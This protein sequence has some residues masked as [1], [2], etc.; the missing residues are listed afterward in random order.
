ML[1]RSGAVVPFDEVAYHRGVV[2]RGMDPDHLVAALGGVERIAD[3][4]EHRHAI[5][6]RVVDR[7]GG[8]LQPDRAMGADQH[9]LVLDLGIAMRE[10]DRGFLMRRG[11]E[12][13]RDILAVVQHRFMQALEARRTGRGEI[14][15]FEA[16][17]H[18]EHEVGPG[19]RLHDR[20]AVHAIGDRVDFRIGRRG[21]PRRPRRSRRC[22]LSLCYQRR[23]NRC[24]GQRCAFQKAP[25]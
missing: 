3:E 22:N 19:R 23:R 6:E 9:R 20:A 12:F 15:E 18:I 24:A 4:Q 25:A 11:D 10:R 17:Q 7:H 16:L 21:G 1:Q 5:A 2:L 8:M 14:I 13:R